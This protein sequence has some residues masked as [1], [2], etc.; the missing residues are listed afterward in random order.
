LNKSPDITSRKEFERN[1]EVLHIEFPLN[2]NF[3]IDKQVAKNMNPLSKYYLM[4][5]RKVIRQISWGAYK[6]Y[7]KIAIQYN[8]ESKN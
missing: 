6:N 7:K 1:P 2:Q 5:S 8:Y 3:L 4:N